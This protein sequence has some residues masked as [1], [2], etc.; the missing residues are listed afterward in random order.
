MII[1]DQVENFLLLSSYAIVSRI[2][3]FVLSNELVV[4]P[5]SYLFVAMGA[6]T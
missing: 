2:L 1:V 6:L 5:F 4:Y 3:S